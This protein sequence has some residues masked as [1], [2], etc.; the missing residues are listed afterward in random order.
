MSPA[1]SKVP[2]PD[3]TAKKHRE[4]GAVLEGVLRQAPQA[5]PDWGRRCFATVSLGA[6]VENLHKIR[7]AMP[8]AAVCAVV[9]AD[10][11]GHGAVPV[12]RALAAA[13]VDWLGVALVEE[14]IELRKAGI[15]EPILVWGATYAAA[16]SKLVE[17]N[18]TPVLGRVDQF[19]SLAAVL[20]GA[21]VKVHVEIDTGMAR[22]GVRFEDLRSFLESVAPLRDIHIDGLMT[23][24]ANAD[25]AGH[26]FNKTQLQRWQESVHT[27]A[28]F[29]VRP[30]WLHIANSP[31]TVSDFSDAD[32]ANLVRVG[33]M[34]YGLDPMVGTST[35]WH[36][37]PAL[38]WVTEV[39]ACHELPPGEPVSY[40][41]HW[42]AD[43]RSRIAT[44]AVG[45]AD[46]YPRCLSNKAYVLVHGQRVRLVGEVCMDFCM[47]DV[48]D[49]PAVCQGDEVVLIGEQGEERI[50]CSEVAEW[51]GTI[52]YEIVSR[53][54]QRVPRSYV[55]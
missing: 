41:S 53:I 35:P 13:G 8:H 31:G 48:T 16:F 33:L 37:S 38:R 5:V 3:V 23:H 29:G 12:A 42:R 15:S 36:L 46:G 7:N 34:L 30:S 28:S 54:S 51:A 20:G 43:R 18:L 21:S 6:I 25:D 44:L 10:A 27:A 22:T 9:K 1:Q 26:S 39:V 50:D 11:Y 19:T 52:S 45:Y 17:Y 14:G 2:R 47:V 24:P 32:G 55:A 4:T 49:V 40:G